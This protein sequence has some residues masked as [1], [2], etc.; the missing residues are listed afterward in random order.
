MCFI[1]LFLSL[2]GI[3]HLQS[4]DASVECVLCEYVMSELD[5]ILKDNNS[6]EAIENALKMVCSKLPS[7]ISQECSDF[8][9]QYADLVIDL[10]IQEGDPKKV[11]TALSLC[12]ASK[13][14]KK[15]LFYTDSMLISCTGLVTNFHVPYV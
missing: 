9:N 11:C 1:S 3:S 4:V 5:N 6:K 7:T 8:V 10:L 15:T 12:Q 14:G 2:L 13:K